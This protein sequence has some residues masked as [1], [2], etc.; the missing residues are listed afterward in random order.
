[1]EVIL[2]RSLLFQLNFSG[3]ILLALEAAGATFLSR[4]CREQNSSCLLVVRFVKFTI[5]Q[6]TLGDTLLH[7]LVVL[8][9]NFHLYINLAV[10]DILREVPHYFLSKSSRLITGMIRSRKLALSFQSFF[11]FMRSNLLLS[12]CD[13]GFR[14]NLKVF[15]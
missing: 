10:F 4:I 14:Q 12:P 3:W 9:M 7:N 15:L 2:I 8:R 1:M 13:M 6:N 5:S 11:N